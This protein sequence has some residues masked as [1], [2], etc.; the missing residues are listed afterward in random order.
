MVFCLY[1]F[2]YEKISNNAHAKLEDLPYDL[3]SNWTWIRFSNLVNFVSGKT[4]ERHNPKYW[5][6]GKSLWFSIADIKELDCGIIRTFINKVLIIA[7]EVIES[8]RTQ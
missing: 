1:N 5:N 6:D 4:S 7:P 3:P 8:H 2:Y